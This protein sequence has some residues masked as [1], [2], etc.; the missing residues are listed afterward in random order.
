VRI[1]SIVDEYTRVCI[2]LK[3]ARSFLA[4]NVIDDLE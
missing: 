3:A 2:L 4:G 1:L